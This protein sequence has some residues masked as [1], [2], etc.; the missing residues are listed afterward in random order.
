MEKLKF[1][2]LCA[3]VFLLSAVP[4]A[5]G[6]WT[7][8]DGH[9]MHFPQLPDP[10]GWDVDVQNCTLA[11]D[12]KCSETGPVEDIHFWVSWLYDQIG[13]IRNVHV[14]IYNDDRSG[15]FSKPGRLLWERNFNQYQF[16]V[17]DIPQEGNQGWYKPC[18]RE[19][20]VLPDN[21]KLFF[22]VNITDIDEPFTQKEGT[23]YWLELQLSTYEGV[24]GWKSSVEQFEDD[25]V[26][27]NPLGAWQELY[28]PRTG[29][30]LDLAFVITGKEVPTEFEYGDA[31]EGDSVNPVIAYPSLGVNGWFP[32]CKTVLTAG[33]VEHASSGQVYFGVPGVFPGIDLELDGN[34][35]LC[36]PPNCFPPYDQD[37]CF[38]DGDAGLI[39]PPS[40]TIQGNVVVP[41]VAGQTGALGYVCQQAQWGVNVDI[42][43]VNNS[44]SE[45]YVNVLADWT[46]NGQ[47]GEIASCA[48]VAAQEN[49]LVNFPVPPGY[50]GPLSAIGPPPFVIGPNGGYVWLRF[51]ITDLQVPNDWDGDGQFPEGE[52]E[53]Y[54]VQVEEPADLDFGDAPERPYRTTLAANG[55][56]HVI[57]PGFHLGNVPGS[58]DPEPDGQPN[59]MAT[60]DD[61]DGNDDEDG[62]IFTSPLIPS[63]PATV[64]V[65]ASADGLLDAWIDFYGDGSWG[66]PEDRIFAAQ[67]LLAGVNQ[68]TFMVPPNAIPNITT[69]ARFRFSSNGG[70]PYFGPAEDGEVEDYMVEIE[71]KPPVKHLKWSQPPIE[72]SPRLQPTRPYKLYAITFQYTDQLLSIDPDTGA[73]TLIGDVNTITPF[74]LSDLG[75]RLY[76]F[77]KASN[78]ILRLDPANGQTLQTININPTGVTGEGALAF[79]SDG[80]GF[81]VS[82]L[83]IDGNLWRFDITVPS[84]TYIGLF[85]PSMDGLD[86]NGSGVLYG[87]N[88][89]LGIGG[90]YEL[91]TIDQ[92]SGATT[93]VGSTGVT[94]SGSVG[95]LTFAPDGTLYAELNDS[96]YTLNPA[97]AAATLVGPIGFSGI[98]GLTAVATVSVDAQ[99]PIYCGWDEA[100]WVQQSDLIPLCPPLVADDF[101]CLGTMPVTSVHWWGSYIGW[102]APAPP[103][104]Q[105]P[106]AWQIRF[107]SNVS[108]DPAGD[109]PYSQPY[110]LLQEVKVDARRVSEELAGIDEYPQRPG[111]SCFQ[112]YLQLDPNEWFWQK[113]YFNSTEGNIFW[114]SV[115]AVYPRDVEI[116][117][118]WGWKTRP[119]SWMD[120]AVRHELEL[121]QPLPLC[122]WKPLKGFCKDSY[123]VA[124][125]L[126]TDPDW[127][128]WEQPF[129]GIRRWRHYH[130]EESLATERTI[131]E[132]VTKYI[133]KPD[134]SPTGIDVDATYPIRAGREPQLLADDFP[135]TT[136]GPI[137]DIHIWGSWNDDYLPEGNPGNVT[138]ALSIHD[139]IPASQSQTGYSMP[140]ELRWMRQFQ[141]GAFTVEQI[142][143]DVRE[144]YYNPCWG[145]YEPYNHQM[146]WRYSFYIDPADAFYQKGSPDRP[147]VYWLDV[148]ARPVDGAASAQFG[149]KTSLVHWN[150]DAVW[151]VGVEPYNDLWN[152][153]LYPPEHPY[154]GKSIDLAFEITTE[155]EEQE[156]TLRRLV[157]DD[158]RCDTNTPVTA[159]VW[160]GSYIGYNYAAC[161]CPDIVAPPVKPDYFL[162]TIWSDVPANPDEPDS[163]SHP[164]EKVWQYNA[165]HYDEVLVGYDKY[166]EHSQP[167]GLPAACEPV[168]RYS[169]RLPKENWFRQKDVNDI[170]WFS[171]VAVY[172]EAQEFNYP[173]GWTNHK[174]VFNDDAVAGYGDLG[175]TGSA[176]Q[177]EELYDQTGDSE[178]MSFMLF[179]WPWPPCWG[180]LTQCHGDVDGDGWVKASDFLALKASWYKCYPDPDYNPCADFDR[181]GCVK[182]SDFL[183]L[184]AYWYLSPPADCPRGGVWP[185]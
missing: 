134:I 123:D 71:F 152:E 168:F 25:A 128:K 14:A 157:A 94:V 38:Q 88:Q 147:V 13:S 64:D 119:W 34:G 142:P 6:H 112:Y 60:G 178:D 127:I 10:Q 102:D 98:S 44:N 75:T 79:R 101:R 108:A 53:D 58:I 143:S 49:I 139:D 4:V 43:I 95:G 137:T 40:Y 156:L 91:Y 92:A 129:T 130:D 175:G 22:Q 26:F 67:P 31:P 176:W 73:G 54:L 162:L 29:E 109:P 24:V 151:A 7:P 61:N 111:D 158:W 76:T 37:E 116:F 70:L 167:G 107:W 68:L 132:P 105:Q 154:A 46:Q 8:D 170:Y 27:L 171:V 164:G 138:F 65:I 42:D 131:V 100:S 90:M 122:V 99:P 57:V 110:R 21:H 117:A 97:T 48:T 47:W 126:D 80:I 120:D 2:L 166:C 16:Q 146:V 173:W 39:M 5:S 41:C 135:C 81:L 18:S 183:I 89:P 55:A 121:G 78:S 93:L 74:G 185:P 56:R 172:D 66:Q 45:M 113:D 160:W 181:D 184:K 103:P 133:Q 51:S 114:L 106:T 52:S 150:D 161:Q 140:G 148:Q 136:S 30:S 141:P 182:A 1:L 15:E 50:V 62:V 163:Y 9:K 69:F 35:G 84:S 174:H 59:A 179:T 87:L 180:S 32:T 28:D 155:R 144:G 169:V 82:S 86:F 20:V 85:V 83:A 72:I 177:W 12:W 104:Q 118:P 145:S 165:Y 77:D 36:P 115:Q 3:L 63:R 153:L 125:E 19:P 33:Y 96:L 124:F 23:I 149:W 11:D 17:S 159:A